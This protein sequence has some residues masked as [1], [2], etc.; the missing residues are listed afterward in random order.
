MIG[1]SHVATE[2]PSPTPRNRRKDVMGFWII[3]YSGS[4]LR[5]KPSPGLLLLFC[6]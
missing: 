4:P 5:I 3:D 2:A 6:S 1:R